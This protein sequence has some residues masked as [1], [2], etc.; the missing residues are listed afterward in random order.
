MHTR[1]MRLVPSLPATSY[2]VSLLLSCHLLG[3][4]YMTDWGTDG[5]TLFWHLSPWDWERCL[6]FS[7]GT[8]KSGGGSSRFSSIECS[9]AAW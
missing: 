1:S 8:V 2:E 3:Y 9:Q 7:A 5:E 6:C 4:R